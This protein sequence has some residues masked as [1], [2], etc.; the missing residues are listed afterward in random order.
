MV[1]QR[2]Q[3]V[4]ILYMI[5]VAASR[6]TLEFLFERPELCNLVTH[7]FELSDGD[8]IRVDTWTLRMS[9]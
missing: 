7:D 3:N 5:S 1:R 4:A 9:T 6:Y 2:L 8:L